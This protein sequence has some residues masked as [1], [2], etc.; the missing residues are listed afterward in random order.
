MPLLICACFSQ[1][2]AVGIVF[3]TEANLFQ[4]LKFIKN[5]AVG[6]K[7]SMKI[8]KNHRSVIT[9]VTHFCYFS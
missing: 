9:S 3:Y 2:L 5:N 6:F 4:I 8:N 1:D 7:S